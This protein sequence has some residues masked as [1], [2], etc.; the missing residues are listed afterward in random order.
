MF[1]FEERNIEEDD[2]QK[3]SLPLSFSPSF[4]PLS[5]PLS[6]SLSLFL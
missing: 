2:K 6:L 4:L 3:I 1:F 5:L